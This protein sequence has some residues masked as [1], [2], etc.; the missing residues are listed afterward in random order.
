VV[1]FAA[2]AGS[3]ELAVHTQP[4]WPDAMRFYAAHGFVAYGRD[5]VDV[6][7]RRR[8]NGAVP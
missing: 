3:E 8:I 2:R 5:D 7:L 6:Y 4:E 1:E